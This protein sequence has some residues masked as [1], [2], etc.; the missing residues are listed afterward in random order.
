M[1]SDDDV[2]AVPSDLITTGEAL[3]ALLAADPAVIAWKA[4]GCQRGGGNVANVDTE[5]SLEPGNKLHLAAEASHA[6][7]LDAVLTAI[8][9]GTLTAIVYRDGHPQPQTELEP[10]FWE[11]DFRGSLSLEHGRV[12]LHSEHAGR[13]LCFTRRAW[14]AWCKKAKPLAV[15]L[16]I[17]VAFTWMKKEMVSRRK[18]DKPK[19]RDTMVVAVMNEFP[20]QL[21]KTRAKKLFTTVPKNLKDRRGPRLGSHRK[22]AR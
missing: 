10:S 18:F 12:R 4:A 15:P 13:P 14:M 8:R 21:S 22:S 9:D 20:G 3:A 16:A 5:P 1:S 17:E 19:D 2:V 11:N 7:V 6:R